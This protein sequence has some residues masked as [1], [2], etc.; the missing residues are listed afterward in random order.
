[1]IPIV[2]IG[3][4]ARR[5]RVHNLPLIGLILGAAVGYAGF[6][7]VRSFFRAVHRTSIRTALVLLGC[8]AAATLFAFGEYRPSP[9]ERYYG[10]PFFSFAFIKR[11]GHWLD[12]LGPLTF[13]ALIGN[14]YV[15]F[16]VPFILA[17]AVRRVRRVS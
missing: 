7:S 5:K 15:G 17:E 11:N 12:Y 14:L 3:F 9:T 2:T 8:V 4:A 16:V 6:L 10:L 13:P 1:M